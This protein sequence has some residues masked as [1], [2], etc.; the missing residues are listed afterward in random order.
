MNVSLNDTFPLNEPPSGYS[1]APAA[2][3][4]VVFSCLGIFGNISVFLA[5][6]RNP[7]MRSAFNVLLALSSFMHIA[8]LLPQWHFPMLFRQGA[9]TD[10]YMRL[11]GGFYLHVG[12]IVGF[13]C[14]GMLVLFAGLDRLMDLALNKAY[15]VVNKCVSLL[16]VLLVCAAQNAFLV[17][18]GVLNAESNP[19]T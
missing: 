13:T 10:G 5:P 14:G 7:E 2:L 6:V 9:S 4:M 11:S 3:F 12:P 16:L 18:F 8:P 19:K 17:L 15:G 1:V